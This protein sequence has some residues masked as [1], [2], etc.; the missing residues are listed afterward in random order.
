MSEQDLKYLTEEELEK[1]KVIAKEQRAI[2]ELF[3]KGEPEGIGYE[4]LLKRE[5]KVINALEALTGEPL[6][7][8]TK[9]K[10]GKPILVQTNK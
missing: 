1:L 7:F 6:S 8:W 5:L 2:T 4:E 3:K 10:D 9:D